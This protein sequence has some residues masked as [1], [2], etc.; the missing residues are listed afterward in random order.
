[1]FIS[2]GIDCDTAEIIKKNNLREMAFPFDWVVTYN[3][4]AK[5]IQNNFKDFLPNSGSEI[6]NPK[7]NSLFLHHKFPNNKDKFIRRIRRM[8]HILKTTKERV[9]FIR[10]GHVKYHHHEQN[11]RYQ[12]IKCDILDAED[13]N[14]VLKEKYPNLKYTI[15]VILCCNKCYH[16]DKKYLSKTDNVRIFKVIKEKPKQDELDKVLKMIINE[17]KIKPKKKVR[18]HAGIVQSGGNKGKL[19]KGYRYSG[20]KTS[21]G[22]PIIVK[23]KKKKC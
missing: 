23:C 2:I 12:N 18:K 13:L 7:S 14:K 16:Q 17:Y 9:F 10:K 6:L 22:L 8:D 19:K 11:G 4:V 20:K 15:I 21:T 1:M 3:G 5:I